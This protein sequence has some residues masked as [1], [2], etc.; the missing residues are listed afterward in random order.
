[1]AIISYVGTELNP[2][3]STF[4]DWLTKT[5]DIITDMGST[6]V[7]IDGENVGNVV[8]QGELTANSGVISSLESDQVTIN[9]GLSV[10]ALDVS[11]NADIVMLYVTDTANL[12]KLNVSSNTSL[13]NTAITNL[14]VTGNTSV[15]D[16]D[17]SGNIQTVSIV[18]TGNSMFESIAVNNFEVTG[19]FNVGT[20]GITSNTVFQ[21]ILVTGNTVFTT[22][23][24][25]SVIT[26]TIEV[27]TIDVQTDAFFTRIES[28]NNILTNVIADTIQADDLT[29]TANTALTRLTVSANS[30]LANTAVTGVFSV[31]SNTT[32]ANTA[33]SSLTITGN[34]ALKLPSGLTS[35]RPSGV[36]GHVRFNESLSRFEGFDGIRWG[37]VG[38][39]NVSDDTTTDATRYLTF[40]SNTS[41]T[42]AG[43]TVSSTKLYFNPSTGQLNATE[44]NSL[45]DEAFKY[46]INPIEDALSII[47][48]I[49]GISFNWK[50]TGKKSLGVSAQ[51]L[52]EVLPDLVSGNEVKT[53]NY[54]GLIA[55][56]LQAIKELQTKVEFLGNEVN[57]KR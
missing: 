22:V 7:S 2:A 55:V 54:N 44:F 10:P 49:D 31:S 13:S 50:E 28:A 42:A 45:S 37:A 4:Q 56:L 30:S 14:S 35:D 29:V 40:V 24:A 43:A 36:T 21:N 39:I 9:T 20:I 17:V 15:T 12:N 48:N 6:V 1:M 23:Y 8:L 11:A 38:G 16:I 53:V 19:V 32:L 27:S 34:G 51:K 57:N 25:N 18:A 3:N 47:K 26:N 52:N 33:I 5:N 41:D 46:N